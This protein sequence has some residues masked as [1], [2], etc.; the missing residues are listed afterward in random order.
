M[1]VIVT[2]LCGVVALSVI[3]GFILLL[4]RT[5]EEGRKAVDKDLD[6]PYWW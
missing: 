5:V 4:L 3:A 6:T 2:L 1:F